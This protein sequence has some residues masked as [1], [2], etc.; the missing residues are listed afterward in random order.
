MA[1]K[2]SVLILRRT[3]LPFSPTL[4]QC[5]RAQPADARSP[6]AQLFLF[7]CRQAKQPILYRVFGGVA[8]HMAS[9]RHICSKSNA[10]A[11]KAVVT[12]ISED[13]G[14]ENPGRTG[15]VKG[16]A[17]KGPRHRSPLQ[18]QMPGAGG[19]ESQA[20]RSTGPSSAELS[21]NALGCPALLT[22]GQASRTPI[23]TLELDLVYEMDLCGL[24]AFLVPSIFHSTARH[25]MAHQTGVTRTHQLSPLQWQRMM[26]CWPNCD[27]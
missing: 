16:V 21:I 1:L 9:V 11:E 23:R 25:R 17:A 15:K 14:D 7:R 5:Q 26:K 20:A 19:T 22:P 27:S 18:A 4:A 10:I 12:R 2:H 8:L 3:P 24:F 13:T 6:L